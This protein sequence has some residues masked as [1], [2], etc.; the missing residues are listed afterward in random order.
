[1]KSYD[2]LCDSESN[3]YTMNDIE[4]VYYD[5]TEDYGLSIETMFEFRE[6]EGDRAY[7]KQ[8]LER[9]TEW[10][11]SKG[12]ST[13]NKLWL[14][15]VFTEGYNINKRFKTIEEVYANFKMLVNGYCSL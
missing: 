10:M 6:K 4:I 15:G 9:L 2:D 1:M 13:E 14:Y 12:Y 5:D 7:L 8:L 11:K 3:L